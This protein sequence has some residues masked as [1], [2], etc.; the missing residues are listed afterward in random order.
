MRPCVFALAMCVAAGVVAGERPAPQTPRLISR[1]EVIGERA[2]PPIWELQRGDETLWILGS[3][4]P[5]PRD[6]PWDSTAIERR[7]AQSQVIV[8]LPGMSLGEDIGFFRGLFLIPS[9]RKSQYNPD[10]QTLRDVLPPATYARWAKARARWLDDDEDRDRLRPINAAFEL[11]QTAL[12][13]TGLLPMAKSVVPS[14]ARRHDVEIL[15]ARLKVPVPSPRKSLK[16]YNATPLA[17]VQCLEETLDRLDA[18][19]G[20]MRERAE[21]WSVGDIAHLRALPFHD[22]T[23]TC[24]AA[25]GSGDVARKHGIVDLP[26]QLRARWLEETRKAFASHDRVFAT[27]PV[28]ML[29]DD[30][31]VLRALQ[32]EGFVLVPQDEAPDDVSPA[33]P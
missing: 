2:S 16:Q 25:L 4:Y 3:L 18:D 32:A 1:I 8:G 28:Q 31:G 11:Y 17:D 13:R 21:A 24:L 7:I 20:H 14:L 12:E 23:P 9:L 26:A 6:V 5:V 22:Q 29:L 30:D 33:T 15:D 19:L 27:L 10:K